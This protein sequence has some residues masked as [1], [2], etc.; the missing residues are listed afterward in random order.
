MFDIYFT[1]IVIYEALKSSQ[2]ECVI[3]RV[4]II[5]IIVIII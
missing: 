2:N 3:V 5:I 4:I 1:I